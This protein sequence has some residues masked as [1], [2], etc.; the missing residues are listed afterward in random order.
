[1]GHGLRLA[2]RNRARGQEARRDAGFEHIAAH[3]ER[4]SLSSYALAYWSAFLGTDVSAVD[5]AGRD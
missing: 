2:K 3:V 5:L 4:R 1:M